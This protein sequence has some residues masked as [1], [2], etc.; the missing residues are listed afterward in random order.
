MREGRGWCMASCRTAIVGVEMGWCNTF[1]YL[2]M[3]AS[4]L[5]GS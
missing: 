1:V 3:L 4:D 2:G 5:K